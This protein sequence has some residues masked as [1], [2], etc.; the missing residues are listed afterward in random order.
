MAMLMVGISLATTMFALS[1][2]F[3]SRPLPYARP[4]RLILIDIDTT[5]FLS[6]S[7]G[8]PPDYPVLRDWQARKDLF[9]GLAAF[10]RQDALRVRLSDRVVALEAIA[11]SANMF[12]V[13]GVTVPA[14]VTSTV[15]GDEVWLTAHA[16][17]GPLANVTR[18]NRTLSLLPLGSLQ[19]TGLLPSSFLVPEPT[20]RLAVDAL[21]EMAPGRIATMDHGNTERLSMVGR[22]RDGVEATQAEAA[23]S[24]DA[25]ARRFGVTVRPLERAMKAQQRSLAAGALLAGLLVLLVAAA[26]TLGMALTRGLFRAHQVAMLEV[27]GAN[28][29]RIARLLLAEAVCVAAAGTVG[30]L[31]LVP[32]LFDAIVAVVPRDFIAL[33]APE[34]SARVAAFAGLAGLIACGAWW[35]GSLL[36]W[37][38]GL[39]TGL[40]EAVLQEGRVVRAIRFGLTAGQ[41]AVTLALLTGAGLLVESYLNLVRQDTGMAGETMALSVSYGPDVAGATLRE[42]IDRT[43]N[44]LRRL[45]GVRRAAAVVG[46]M[47]DQFSVTG[48]VVIGTVAP[49]ELLWVTPDYFGTVGMSFVA[50]RPLVDRDAGGRGVV[51][52][53]ALVARYLGGHAAIGDPLRVGG[54]PSPIVGIVRDSRRRALDEAPRPAVF[55]VLDGNVPGMRVTYLTGGTTTS[56]GLWESLV[57]R[58]SPAAVVLDGSTL[59]ARL[60]RTIQARSFAT[61]VVGLFAVATIIVTAAGIIGVVGYGVARRTREIGIR[62]A[63]GATSGGV[64]WLAMRDACVAAGVGAGMGLIAVVGVSDVVSSLLYGVSPTDWTTLASTTL[65]LIGLAA[66]AAI[67]P[68]RRAGRV[69]PTIALREE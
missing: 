27:L 32:L 50:G 3:L 65:A 48:V 69:S 44:G 46:E 11:V 41:A 20:E 66:A 14:P 6:G 7:G 8:L 60:A 13:L 12:D 61:L 1:D 59:R 16:L 58:V 38:R 39:H 34:L 30:A 28:R 57:H 22:L 43:V 15:F 49:V 23:L 19:V 9:D 4:S 52:N 62:L 64:T 5:R 54:R 56:A 36:A 37:L 25:T 26:N 18:A 68:A 31:L 51:V 42:T 2:P 55:R 21:V 35:I 45:P 17:T 53:E 24:A 63:M 40:R 47:A 10:T 29:T 33:G 67:V